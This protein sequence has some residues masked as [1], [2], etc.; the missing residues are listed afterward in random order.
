MDILLW[1]VILICWLR[2]VYWCRSWV[3]ILS[4]TSIHKRM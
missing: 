2:V 1:S 4:Y 3:G